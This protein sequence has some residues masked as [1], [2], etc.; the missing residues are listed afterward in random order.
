MSTTSPRKIRIAIA[1]LVGGFAVMMAILFTSSFYGQNPVISNISPGQNP[2]RQFTVTRCDTP[3]AASILEANGFVD[4]KPRTS[5]TP[6]LTSG[7][8]TPGNKPGIYEFVLKPGSTGAVAMSYDFCQGIGE[9]IFN[10]LDNKTTNE[11]LQ[12]F[13]DS[14]NSTSRGIYKLNAD[15]LSRSS[16]T[17]QD[18]F[19]SLTTKND[20]LPAAYVPHAN[21]TGVDIHASSITKISDQAVKV[22]Y[23]VS[24]E[25]S[26]VNAT[27]ILTNFYG[28]CP[29]ELLTIGDK[30]NEASQEWSKGPFYGCVG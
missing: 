5:A 29:G 14:F 4:I 27:Y 30:P 17:S 19:G 23:M 21:G 8:P 2:D 3:P 28:I 6:E 24:A 20:A 12:V 9:S 26:A 10:S 1:A 13:F 16:N 11:E 18:P 25:P 22:T 7:V 15:S